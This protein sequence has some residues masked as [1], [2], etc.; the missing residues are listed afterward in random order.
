MFLILLLAMPRALYAH[1]GMPGGMLFS[2]GNRYCNTGTQGSDMAQD[3]S[4]AHG[5]SVKQDF[6]SRNRKGTV[7]WDLLGGFTGKQS[8]KYFF[9]KSTFKKGGDDGER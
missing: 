4:F 2:W 5:D 3:G 9:K 6:F 7:L 1:C 8:A